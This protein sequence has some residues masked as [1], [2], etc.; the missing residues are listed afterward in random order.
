[1]GVRSGDDMLILVTDL[2]GWDARAFAERHRRHTGDSKAVWNVAIDE[3][4]SA[5]DAPCTN[6]A[7]GHHGRADAD[8][9]PLANAHF[10]AVVEAGGDVDVIAN[11]VVMV[12]A[13]GRVQDDVGPD[14]GA[15]IHH[16]ARA[17]H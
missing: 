1:A 10:T 4:G 14:H 7:P 11:H 2:P 8:Q 12:D 13:A 15:G 5:D 16:D 6:A 17:N 9:R 3:R